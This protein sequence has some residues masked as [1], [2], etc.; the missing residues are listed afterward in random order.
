MARFAVTV[1]IDAPTEEDAVTIKL[2]LME[3]SD[4]KLDLAA[5]LDW[6]QGVEYV[7]EE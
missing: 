6:Q 2:A 1:F 7:D 3:A 5:V 4:S